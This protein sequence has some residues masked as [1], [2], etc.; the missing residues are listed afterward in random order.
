[1]MAFEDSEIYQA[2]I[3]GDLA[4]LGWCLQDQDLNLRDKQGRSF[5]HLAI[6]RGQQEV[7]GI[8][9]QK[10]FLGFRDEK[11]DTALDLSLRYPAS[12]AF[13]CHKLLK[14]FT[15]VIFPF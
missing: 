14:R 9:A 10:V 6:E 13:L 4:A 11:G 15:Y 5:L 3:D 1:M 12:T 8:L 2:I 7:I